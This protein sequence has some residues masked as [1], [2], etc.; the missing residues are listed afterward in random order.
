MIARSCV[1][2]SF[3]SK[4]ELVLPEPRKRFNERWTPALYAEFLQRLDEVA[5]THVSFRCS[6]TPVFFPKAL[7]DKMSRYGQELYQQLAGNQEYRRASAATIPAHFRVPNEPDHPLFV[8][9]DFGLVR[10]PDGTL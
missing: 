6:E 2:A 5:G 8:Q 9:A 3:W 4:E 1:L 7:V 10:G